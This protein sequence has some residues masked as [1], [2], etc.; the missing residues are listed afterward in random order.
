MLADIIH[1]I[2][3]IERQAPRNIPDLTGPL[4]GRA[5][6]L[7]Q[8]I[9]PVLSPL[10]IPQRIQTIKEIISII[11]GRSPIAAV[12]LE[13]TRRRYDD[14][15]NQLIEDQLTKSE[16]IDYVKHM[17]DYEKHVSK[18]VSIA[19]KGKSKAGKDFMWE[20]GMKKKKNPN[21]N[22]SKHIQQTDS[23]CSPSS[24]YEWMIIMRKWKK[25]C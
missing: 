21:W 3:A 22:M 11:D 7:K 12:F 16:Y 6:N 4:M 10:S 25:S 18:V 1:A 23:Q 2:V 24:A 17:S 15:L 20:Y 8:I 9:D 5:D 14:I 19:G 13:K